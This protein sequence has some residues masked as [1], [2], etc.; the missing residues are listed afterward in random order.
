ML[1]QCRTQGSIVP[2]HYPVTVWKAWVWC[3][4]NHHSCSTWERHLCL[5]RPSATIG[6]CPLNGAQTFLSLDVCLCHSRCLCTGPGTV[7]SHCSLT[8]MGFLYHLAPTKLFSFPRQ[9]S[10]LPVDHELLE[11]RVSSTMSLHPFQHLQS[12][13]LQGRAHIILSGDFCIINLS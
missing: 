13:W 1:L 8:P 4:S 12:A 5:L 7:F 9:P 3:L 6:S 2:G 10:P 11:G